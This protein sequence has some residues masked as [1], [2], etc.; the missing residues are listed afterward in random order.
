MNIIEKDGKIYIEVYNYGCLEER[1]IEEF[2]KTIVNPAYESKN[3]Y[4]NI[5]EKRF[6]IARA[7]REKQLALDKETE[8]KAK[9]EELKNTFRIVIDLLGDCGIVIRNSGYRDGD[10][11]FDL[12]RPRTENIALTNNELDNLY[13]GILNHMLEMEKNN[14][15]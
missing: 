4:F 10:L 7:A 13:T 2:E 3:D 8:R 12:Y 1:T 6:N 9:T 15:H 5:W 11:G 14:E